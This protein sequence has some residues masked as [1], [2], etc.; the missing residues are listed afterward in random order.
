MFNRPI[1]SANKTLS[2]DPKGQL[3]RYSLAAVA[4]GVSLCALAQPMQGEVVVTRKTLPL[5]PFG[6]ATNIDLN[7]DGVTDFTFYNYSSFGSQELFVTDSGG[8]VVGAGRASG[9]GYASALMR[10]ATIGPTAKFGP[11]S[12]DVTVIE[13][14]FG[15]GY[16]NSHFSG[17]WKDAPKNRYLGVRFK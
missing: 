12:S 2:Q 8:G 3:A 6:T 14:G 11:A 17:N 5:S 7:Q 16:G 10:G 1:D 13:R 9:F 15:V 4:A